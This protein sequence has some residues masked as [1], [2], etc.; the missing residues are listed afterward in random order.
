MDSK[1]ML[2]NSFDSGL[3]GRSGDSGLGGM[4]IKQPSY[5][6]PRIPGL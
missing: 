1:M 2:F 3:L 4:E 5:V 6:E